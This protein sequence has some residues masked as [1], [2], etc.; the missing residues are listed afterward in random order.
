MGYIGVGELKKQKGNT[1]ITENNCRKQQPPI[2]PG[3]QRRVWSRF[4]AQNLC[5][6]T[7]WMLLILLRSTS[8]SA[9]KHWW[10]SPL[11]LLGLR[12]YVRAL[13]GGKSEF[14]ILMHLL[15]V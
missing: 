5:R 15:A 3:E 12:V 6:G 11:L 10:L 7:A 9:I 1:G 14:L 4:E 8:E 2:G 13:P